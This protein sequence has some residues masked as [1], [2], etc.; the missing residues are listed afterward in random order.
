VYHDLGLG[1]EGYSR[2]GNI[3][4]IDFIQDPQDWINGFDAGF[5]NLPLGAGHTQQYCEGYMDGQILWEDPAESMFSS[6]VATEA[7]GFFSLDADIIDSEFSALH[8]SDDDHHQRTPKQLSSVIGSADTQSNIFIRKRD[9]LSP[10]LHGVPWDDVRAFEPSTPRRSTAILG[11]TYQPVRGFERVFDM[12]FSNLNLS[13]PMT[14]STAQTASIQ[15]HP[16]LFETPTNS[17][18]VPYAH[19]APAAPAFTPHDQ[20]QHSML[21]SPCVRRNLS[22]AKSARFQSD[23]LAAHGQ[24]EAAAAAISNAKHWE[25]KARRRQ[26]KNDSQNRIRALQ[27]AKKPARWR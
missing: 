24:L 7:S 2:R 1:D 4:Q 27:R 26:D 23:L 5:A 11:E 6:S 22:A 14:P 18:A 16:L 15:A 25:K 20:Y 3:S 19:S 12:D 8:S 10:H 21:A 9:A 17:H 13:I